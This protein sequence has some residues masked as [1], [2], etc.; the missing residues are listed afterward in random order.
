M[1]L[2]DILKLISVN[3]NRLFKTPSHEQS[4]EENQIHLDLKT[5]YYTY[6]LY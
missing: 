5:I 4:D 6:I 1:S 3:F 2:T